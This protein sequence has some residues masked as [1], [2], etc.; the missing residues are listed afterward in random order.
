MDDR[1]LIFTSIFSWHVHPSIQYFGTCATET[2][3]AKHAESAA[4]PLLFVTGTKDALLPMEQI[5]E[6]QKTLETKNP[7]MNDCEIIL[8]EEAG[9]GFVH[10]PQ[11]EEDKTEAPALVQRC[12]NILRYFLLK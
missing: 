8:V 7:T 9:H 3:L 2:E 12:A 11:S 5:E 1:Q 6:L 4:S 10:M